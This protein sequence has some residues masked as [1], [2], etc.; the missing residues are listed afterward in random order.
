ML[1]SYIRNNISKL[2]DLPEEI[3]KINKYRLADIVIVCTGA[4]SAAN[5]AL[6]C[7]TPGGKIIFFA[8]PE[9]WIYLN[10]PINKYW[11]FLL[12]I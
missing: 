10:V 12:L 3:K 9:P 7:A 2:K 11:V 6:E 8:V 1:E 5:Q 4:I